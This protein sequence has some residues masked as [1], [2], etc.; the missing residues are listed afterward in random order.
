MKQSEA[1]RH[2]IK[3]HKHLL[4]AIKEQ[5]Y[6]GQE[7]FDVVF[8]LSENH[9]KQKRVNKKSDRPSCPQSRLP[10]NPANPERD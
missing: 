10:R 6:F 9:R 3:A 5:A 7:L 2:L 1:K 4:R 8:D